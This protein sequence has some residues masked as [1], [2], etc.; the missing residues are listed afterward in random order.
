MV[1]TSILAGLQGWNTGL[2][3]GS[4]TSGLRVWEKKFEVRTIGA[5]ILGS[6]QML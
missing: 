5:V 3:L 1:S 4:L 6:V 2:V